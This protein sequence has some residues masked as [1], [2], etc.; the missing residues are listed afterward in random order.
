MGKPLDMEDDSHIPPDL[1]L[2]YKILKNAGCVPPELTLRKEI[3]QMEDLL[4]NIPDEKEKYRQIKKINYQI[5]KL[6]AMGKKSPLLEET[7]LYYSKIVGKLAG[8][9]G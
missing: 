1:R 3:K 8:N 5:M 4:E 7:Q 2:P 9:K 6:N